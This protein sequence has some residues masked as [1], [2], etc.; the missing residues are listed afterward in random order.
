VR[1]TLTFLA[2]QIERLLSVLEPPKCLAEV[3][4]V[5]WATLWLK[6][7]PRWL[8]DVNTW[9]VRVAEDMAW[10]IGK[11]EGREVLEGWLVAGEEVARFCAGV[12]G[13]DVLRCA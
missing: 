11:E 5:G 3:K 8:C 9:I 10:K 4:L 1:D 2:T 12:K 13:E 7:S 6:E